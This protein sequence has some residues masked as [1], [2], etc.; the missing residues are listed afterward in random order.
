VTSASSNVIY[1]RLNYSL[2]TKI[3]LERA[4]SLFL[5]TLFTCKILEYMIPPQ[6]NLHQAYQCNYRMLR[7]ELSIC[8]ATRA[9]LAD[10]LAAGTS[11]FQRDVEDSSLLLSACYTI[12]FFLYNIWFVYSKAVVFPFASKG[13]RIDVVND[14]KYWAGHDCSRMRQNVLNL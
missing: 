11:I 3:T 1:N 2:R 9:Y 6:M 7:K 8:C 4:A 10:L 12:T 13:D 14:V 5:N